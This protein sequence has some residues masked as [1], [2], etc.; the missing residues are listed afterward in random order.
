[1]G[2][3]PS[4]ATIGNITPPLPVASGGTG[5]TAAGAAGQMLG[6]AAGVP[7]WIAVPWLPQDSSLIAWAYDPV[8]AAA[9]S[10]QPTA[11]QVV[12]VKMRVP[13][14]LISNLW[15]GLN[16][17]GAGLTA[18]QNFAGLYNSA[19]TLLSATADQSVAWTGSFTALPM[20]L[21]TP[22]TVAAG[23]VYVCWF[24]NGTTIPK[25]QWSSSANVVNANI[26]TGGTARFVH[27]PGG[28]TTSMPASLAP[29]ASGDTYWCAVS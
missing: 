9:S 5:L 18:G 8:V 6:T 13:A 16:S 12:G 22:Q 23:F 25:F 17:A 20:A 11:G 15:V 21:T 19:G 10:N 4:V 2:F 28:Q 24:A 1:M 3:Y 7:A 29:G 27:G 26:N 14:G